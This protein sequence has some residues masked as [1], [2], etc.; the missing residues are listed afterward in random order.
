MGVILKFKQTG[1]IAKFS[2]HVN[3]LS[4]AFDVT[5]HNKRNAATNQQCDVPLTRS[6]NKGG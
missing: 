3:F 6:D 4:P 2:W 5:V 1:V